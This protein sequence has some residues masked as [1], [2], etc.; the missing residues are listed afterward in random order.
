MA[1]KAP[2][3]GIFTNESGGEG[4]LKD[5]KRRLLT[6]VSSALPHLRSVNK[7]QHRFFITVKQHDALRERV[8]GDMLPS[9]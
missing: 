2:E 4:E 8:R 7:P 3:L 6:K 9:R 1:L 5:Q